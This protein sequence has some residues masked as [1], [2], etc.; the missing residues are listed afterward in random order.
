VRGTTYVFGSSG[1]LFRS[2]KLMYDQQ[3]KSLWNHMRGEPVVGPLSDSGI[4]LKVLPVVTTTWRDWLRAHPDTR[5]LDINTGHVRDYT[6]GRPYGRYFESPDTMFPVSPRSPRLRTK[7]FVFV[8]RLPAQAKVY[9][10]EVLEREPIV[11]DTVAGT[12]VLIVAHPPT[13]TARAFD[14]K[15]LSFRAG[16]DPSEVVEAGTGRV[17]SVEEEGLVNRTTGR[18]LPRLGG[19]LAYW[20]GWFAF[21]PDTPVYRK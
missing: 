8:L 2:N 17:W 5:V 3:T 14:R 4:T 9:P 18:R 10:L 13:R 6:P 16:R 1:F 20:F 21:H 12:A 19:H 15:G 7:E 11:H